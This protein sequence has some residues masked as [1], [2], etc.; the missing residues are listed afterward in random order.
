MF[1][2]KRSEVPEP[3]AE[4]EPTAAGR[5]RHALPQR[6]QR[7]SQAGEIDRQLGA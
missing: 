2:S 5:R 7:E 6:R 3:D 4:D 1:R